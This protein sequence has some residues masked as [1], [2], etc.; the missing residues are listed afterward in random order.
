MIGL[1]AP[2]AATAWVAC[3]PGGTTPDA[4]PDA[5]ADD[6]SDASPFGD[7]SYIDS[8]VDWCEAG[9]PQFVT[10]AGNSCND[11]LYVPCG[12]PADDF[13]KPDATALAPFQ[14][15]RCDQ[16]CKGFNGFSCEVLTYGQVQLLYQA[17]DAGDGAVG[18]LDGG[19]DSATDAAADG[20][21]PNTIPPLGGPFYIS[22]DCTSGGRKPVGLRA[23]RRASKTTNVVGEHLASMAWLE[24]ASVPA[25]A[26]LRAELEALGAPR[27]LLRRIDRA[28]RDERRHARV[29]GKLARRFGAP[30]QPPRLRRPRARGV[31]AIARENAVEGC[32]RETYGALVATWQAAHAGDAS[33]RAS[34]QRIALD[35]TR[36]AALSARVDAFLATK[37]DARAR[38][39]VD[40]ARRRAITALRM[41]TSIEPAPELVAV[42]GIPSASQARALLA[43]LDASVWNDARA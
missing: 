30:V 35:E 20:P 15:N 37:L 19:D 21:D 2:A 14:L 8:Y 28:V 7:A 36:H 29:V 43:G 9:P 33:V 17:L 1:S 10:I 24:A 6:A 25:F 12:A 31:E 13:L 27:A 4:G 23:R 22:C 16:I 39:R 34:M 3:S 41:A 5:T 40:R 32:V 38:A 42:T 11:I 18:L 26:R